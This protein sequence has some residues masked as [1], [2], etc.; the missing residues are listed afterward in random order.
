MPVAPLSAANPH[1]PPSVILT[2]QVHPPFSLSCHVA[3]VS[4]SR[5]FLSLP[6]YLLGCAEVL[7]KADHQGKPPRLARAKRR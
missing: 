7:P 6:G 5:N 1:F 4:H 2:P 3:D